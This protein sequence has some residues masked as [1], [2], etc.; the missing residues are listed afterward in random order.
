MRRRASRGTPVLIDCDY[1]GHQAGYSFRDLENAGEPTGVIY[2]FLM[3]LL[4]IGETLHSNHFLFCW[5]S[6]E[7]ARRDIFPDYKSHRRSKSSPDRAAIHRQFDTLRCRAL[8][9]LGFVNVFQQSGR[10]A[11]DLIAALAQHLIGGAYIV[12]ADED[13]YQILYPRIR[14]FN[15]TSQK[16]TTRETFQKEYRINP[17]EWTLVKA[18]AGCN[19]DDIPGVPGV[20]IVR[21]IQHIREEL[22]PLHPLRQKI[23]ENHSLVN[24]NYKLVQLP[25]PGT[26]TPT[27]SGD[28]TLSMEGLM[29]LCEEYGFGSFQVPPLVERWAAFFAGS[30]EAAPDRARLGK[31]MVKINPPRSRRQPT[32]T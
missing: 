27:I 4:S 23:V 19:S 5:D 24:R 9:D 20:G 7:S 26:I 12:S 8:L 13:L 11:D 18:I 28:D 10:E 1:L 32:L 16:V 15:P 14:M 29:G 25:F 21:A 2:G 30:F 3:R 17:E 6:R 22:A 31:R